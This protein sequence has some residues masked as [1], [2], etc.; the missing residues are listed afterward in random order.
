[1]QRKI[2]ITTDEPLSAEGAPAVA[3]DGTPPDLGDHVNPSDPASESAG[4]AGDS[5]TK[6][7]GNGSGASDYITALQAD[8]EEARRLREEADKRLIYTQAEFQNFRRRK[9]EESKD[10]QKF[11]NSEMIQALF[12]IID[13]FERALSAAEKTKNFD[14]LI[15]GVSGTLK[16][17]QAFLSKAGVTPIEAIGKEFDP[18]FHEAIGHTE[19]SEY[20]ANTVAEEVQRGYIMHDRVLRPT[21]VKVS[22]G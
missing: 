15:G 21:L 4:N 13:N 16:Q 9:E 19:A 1:M 10:L 7:F 8:L 5:S 6:P 3:P 18:N 14:A 22:N 12:P 11:G 2:E 20:A 17:L